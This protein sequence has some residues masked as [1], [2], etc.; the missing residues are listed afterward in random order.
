L[1]KLFCLLLF[2]LNCQE[3]SV[4][5]NGIRWIHGSADCTKNTEDPIQAVQ[6]NSSTWILRQNKCV[7]YEAPFLFLFIGDD[8]ALLMDT[9]ATSDAGAFPIYDTV[10][11]II[12]EWEKENKK[13]L[14]LIV[15]HTHSHGDHW[16]GDGQ[17]KGKPNT[18]IVGLTESDVQQFFQLKDWPEKI[19][20]FE[21]GNRKVEIIP[22]PGHDK[23]SLALY[24]AQTQFLLTGDTFYPGRL[25]VRDWTAFKQ[26]IQR[27]VDF[28]SQHKISYLIGNHIE[29][30]AT[31]GKDYPTGTVW[32]PDEHV[33]PLTVNDLRQL[34]TGLIE[35]G[36][37]PL[38]KVFDHFIV[39]PK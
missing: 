23:T 27:L 24:D 36:E 22:I 33:L 37:Q 35:L 21:L 1:S 18:T 39:V 9:G 17:F 38:R 26:S 10:I 30:S 29:M 32:Q 12:H 5:L 20:T 34:N 6:Y 15:A 14:S 19:N 3:S 2:I 13:K 11:R 8:K 25:Y 4:D 31:T 28:T 16:M 7:N